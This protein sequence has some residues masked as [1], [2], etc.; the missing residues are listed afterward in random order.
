MGERY[1][2]GKCNTAKDDL[3]ALDCWIRAVELG[4]P[5]ACTGIGQHFYESRVAADKER[6]ALF[7]RIGALRGDII[8]R[9]NIGCT[10]YNAGN[11]EIGIRH[12]K[13]AAEAGLQESLNALRNI[14]NA[15]GKEPGKEFIT[16]EYMDFAERACHEAQMEV[17]SEEREKHSGAK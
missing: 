6:A 16:S 9:Y 8:A 1:K 12:W 3:R 7:E 14:Y 17:K 10:E 11:H 15:N 13:I 4:S 2:T 5:A